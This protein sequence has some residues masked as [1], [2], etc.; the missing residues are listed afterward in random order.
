VASCYPRCS[1]KPRLDTTARATTRA[2]TTRETTRESTAR[3]TTRD[4]TRAANAER[5]QGPAAGKALPLAA[6][7]REMRSLL[8]RGCNWTAATTTTTTSGALVGAVVGSVSLIAL[9]VAAMALKY[10][11]VRV[12][13]SGALRL[14]DLYNCVPA[15]SAVLNSRLPALWKRSSLSLRMPS[16]TRHQPSSALVTFTVTFLFFPS[17]F[18]PFSYFLSPLPLGDCYEGAAW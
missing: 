9:V 3:E 4:T 5:L 11:D 7:F 14:A 10:V 16:K 13:L 6:R 8:S 1:C 17:P 2:T 12:G 15:G 18:F